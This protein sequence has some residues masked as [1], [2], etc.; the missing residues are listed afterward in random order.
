MH[1]LELP[2]VR[3]ESA[4]KVVEQLG[5]RGLAA[6]EAEVARRIDDTGAEVMLPG[7]VREH[8]RRERIIVA[9]NPLCEGETAFPFS[10]KRLTRT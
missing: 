5:V 6:E 8:A 9:R 10:S 3:E 7:A 2:A 1:P 4:R